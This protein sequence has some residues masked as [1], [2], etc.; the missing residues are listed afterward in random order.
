MMLY[1]EV[2]LLKPAHLLNGFRFFG[3]NKLVFLEHILHS[4]EFYKIFQF[5]F[6][7]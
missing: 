4:V 6:K 3:N 2:H 7:K 5:S 1:V